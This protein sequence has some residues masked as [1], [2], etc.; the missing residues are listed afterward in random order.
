MKDRRIGIEPAKAVMGQDEEGE[1]RALLRCSLRTRRDVGGE[2]PVILPCVREV[3]KDIDELKLMGRRIPLHHRALGG[4]A[5]VAVPEKTLRDRIAQHVHSTVLT[6]E[7]PEGNAVRIGNRVSLR[8]LAVCAAAGLGVEVP[9]GDIQI[10]RALGAGDGGSQ[11]A[12]ED[13]Q[14]SPYIEA[15]IYSSTDGPGHNFPDRLVRD[16]I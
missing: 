7:G 9:A 12:Q 10:T 1:R 5:Y 16:A 11:G 6:E 2:E 8:G 3:I 15:H 14:G 13:E 4:L